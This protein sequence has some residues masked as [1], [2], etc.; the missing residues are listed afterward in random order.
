[1]SDKWV[2]DELHAG[3]VVVANIVGARGHAEKALNEFYKIETSVTE[4]QCKEFTEST[5]FV[6]PGGPDCAANLE[7]PVRATPAAGSCRCSCPRFS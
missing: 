3:N 4:E 7:M 6:Y 5:C 1:M 2:V